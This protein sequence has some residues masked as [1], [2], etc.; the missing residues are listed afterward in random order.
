MDGWGI[1]QPYSGNSISQSD[2]PVLNELIAK[3][4]SMTLRASGEA[5]GLP[6]GEVGNSEVGHLNLG[7]GRILYQ[8][9]P[10]INKSISDG[11]F[12]QNEALLRAVNHVKEKGSKLHLIGLLSNGCVHSSIDHF[13]ALIAM[14]KNNGLDKVFV[15][16]FHGWTRYALQRRCRI[17]S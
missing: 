7:L 8:D 11:T 15:H 4:P 14:A 5:V 17:Y 2:T 9:L 12:Y 3:Y 10:L 6:W 1:T 16:A 13:F